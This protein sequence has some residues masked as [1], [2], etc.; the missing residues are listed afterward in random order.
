MYCRTRGGCLLRLP[1]VEYKRDEKED[2]KQDWSSLVWRIIV[3]TSL[4]YEH[5][6][7]ATYS[8]KG[9]VRTILT[10][11]IGGVH[12]SFDVSYDFGSPPCR[13]IAGSCFTCTPACYKSL[14]CF[15]APLSPFSPSL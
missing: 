10:S 3:Q 9:E 14:L 5:Q 6:Y 11:H 2:R 7:A 13:A 8:A 12:G 15:S 4:D 1:H